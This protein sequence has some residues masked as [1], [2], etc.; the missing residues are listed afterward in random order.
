MK[1]TKVK[2]KKFVK[3]HK[4]E[5]ITATVAVIATAT[6]SALTNQLAYE[7]GK[8]CGQLWDLDYIEDIGDGEFVVSFMDGSELIYPV[9][10]TE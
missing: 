4:K 7:K 9:N 1:G 8:K 6:I 5:I 10:Y 2:I 3:E